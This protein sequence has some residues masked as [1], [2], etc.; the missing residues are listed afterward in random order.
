MVKEKGGGGKRDRDCVCMCVCVSLCVIDERERERERE[1]LQ[2]S[3][4]YPSTLYNVVIQCSSHTSGPFSC[5][6]MKQW[7]DAGYFTMDLMVCRACDSIMLPLGKHNN[8]NLIVVLCSF[9]HMYMC[10]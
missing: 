9:I 1:K 8:I 2:F 4:F 5:D 3:M 7:F 6:E 10:M